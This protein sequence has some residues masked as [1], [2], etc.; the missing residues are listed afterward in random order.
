MQVVVWLKDNVDTLLGL[1]CRQKNNVI[2]ISS[3]DLTPKGRR[4]F[5]GMP[6]EHSARLTHFSLLV[7]TVIEGRVEL[8]LYRSVPGGWRIRAPGT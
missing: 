6:F 5:I 4:S 8:A 1:E 3:A 7:A 2:N